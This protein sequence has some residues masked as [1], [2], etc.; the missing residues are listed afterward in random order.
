MNTCRSRG[1]NSFLFVSSHGLFKPRSL[2][3]HAQASSHPSQG[4]ES[5]Q[6]RVP[7]SPGPSPSSSCRALP[8]LGHRL[9]GPLLTPSSSKDWPCRHSEHESSPQL[10]ELLE[11]E[12][13]QTESL[14]PPPKWPS[15]LARPGSID[16]GAPAGAE[17]PPRPPG[18][19]APKRRSS[20]PN[21]HGSCSWPH[22]GRAGCLCR[23]SPQ[24]AAP[25][26]APFPRCPQPTLA[27]SEQRAPLHQRRGPA[28]R[29]GLSARPLSSRPSPSSEARGG[30]RSCVHSGR[31]CSCVHARRAC[32]ALSTRGG[33]P[34][35]STCAAMTGPGTH[36]DSWPCT[37]AD[38]P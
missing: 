35:T 22:V 21:S 27:G 18:A 23:G 37:A 15:A 3:E 8:S 25:L 19:L 33:W 2:W 17:K 29:R 20:P 38:A 26:H 32:P 16:L 28:T 24:P 34:H 36:A 11:E 6:T 14:S 12:R 13:G 7:D 9:A 1:R 31:P 10:L 4:C 30:A 5:L